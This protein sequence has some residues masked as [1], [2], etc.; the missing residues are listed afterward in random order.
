MGKCSCGS[1]VTW[2][3]TTTTVLAQGYTRPYT[4]GGWSQ[5]YSKRYYIGDWNGIPEIFIIWYVITYY[6]TK[7]WSC[8]ILYLLSI[9]WPSII[10]TEEHKK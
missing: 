7:N 5:H 8:G 3:R 10:G 4:E 6:D 1:P 2:R 9:D